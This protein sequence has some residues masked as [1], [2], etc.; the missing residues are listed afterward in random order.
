MLQPTSRDR[1][2]PSRA[3]PGGDFHPFTPRQESVGFRASWH[4]P[5]GSVS[6]SPNLW[7]HLIGS[8][9]ALQPG[10]PVAAQRAQLRALRYSLCSVGIGNPDLAGL[11]V[12][13]CPCGHDAQDVRSMGLARPHREALHPIVSFPDSRSV[14]PW[15]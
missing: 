12:R 3:R 13:P 11:V 14:F 8:N 1:V 7:I 4:F 5:L 6:A 15:T 9:Q 2:A 10:A